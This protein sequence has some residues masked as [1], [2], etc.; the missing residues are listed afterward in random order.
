[1]NR[2]LT[3]FSVTA[4]TAVDTWI[5]APGAALAQAPAGVATA[6]PIALK[7]ARL[8]DSVSGTLRTN[9]VVVV[10]GGKIVSVGSGTAIP[11]GARVIPPAPIAPP[12]FERLAAT[13]GSH[14][15]K[16]VGPPPA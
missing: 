12:D 2:T 1:M 15:T 4:L 3:C 8:F 14:G 10:Q 13:A 6:P 7:A 11:A 16:V 9:G 5:A